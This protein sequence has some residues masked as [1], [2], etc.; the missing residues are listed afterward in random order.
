M[1][2]L[3]VVS[4][5][6]KEDLTPSN[7]KRLSFSKG[8]LKQVDS[9]DDDDDGLVSVPADVASQSALSMLFA[10]SRREDGDGLG[11]IVPASPISSRHLS[12]SAP[13][14]AA[15]SDLTRLSIFQTTP[16]A[17]SSE[18]KPKVKDDNKKGDE[19]VAKPATILSVEPSESS[20]KPRADP[21]LTT[22]QSSSSSSPVVKLSSRASI[23]NLRQSIAMNS[24]ELDLLLLRG[25]RLLADSEEHC[26]ES[27]A[28]HTALL[29]RLLFLSQELNS[30]SLWNKRKLTFEEGCR[31]ED[32][33]HVIDRTCAADDLTAR[34]GLGA[35]GGHGRQR[36]DRARELNNDLSQLQA[37]LRIFQRNSAALGVRKPLR[38]SIVCASPVPTSVTS[39]A[40]LSSSSK[41]PELLS[42]SDSVMA[43][44]A[45]ID[46]ALG[47]LDPSIATFSLTEQ[48]E[49]KRLFSSSDSTTFVTYEFLYRFLHDEDGQSLCSLAIVAGAELIFRFILAHWTGI[50]DTHSQQQKTSGPD[51]DLTLAELKAMGF[52][53]KTLRLAGWRY[54]RLIMLIPT[55]PAPFALTAPAL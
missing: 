14:S 29:S 52:E 40:A 32:M 15:S 19:D 12:F 50:A 1:S 24:N 54:V 46:A 28:A 9:D 47:W 49:Y 11:P 13:A 35:P 31:L 45:R 37:D 17:F 44:L 26:C 10:S 6:T 4:S 39:S 16:F 51:S 36:V 34:D 2:P 53:C 21:A 48:S 7:F 8:Q 22:P 18:T 30:L 43:L 38:S 41:K 42:E 27:S 20:A 25:E 55:M 23:A 3:P 33:V 5:T